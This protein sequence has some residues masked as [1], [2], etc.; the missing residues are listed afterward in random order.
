MAE[1]QL[2]LVIISRPDIASLIIGEELL[3]LGDWQRGP[4]VEGCITHGFCDTRI[5]WLDS[6]LLW[7]DDLDERWR[8]A[9]TE[10]VSE[11]IFPSR[12][13]A[14]SGQPSLT[15][16]PIGIPHLSSQDEIP[17]GGK[18]AS[19]P[20]P[21]P[22]LA[23]WF[24]ELKQMGDASDLCDEFSFTLEATHHG[25]WLKT[26]CM[27]IEIGSTESYWG[28]RDAARI[29]A[30]II[31]RGLGLDGGVGIGNWNASAA[32]EKVVVGIGGGHYAPFIGR[33]A[34]HEGV[35][36]GH[37]LANHSL[38]MIRPDEQDDGRAG[39]TAPSGNWS[40]AIDS[41]IESTR[42]AFPG[43]DVW[44]YLDR[45]SFKGWQRQA[46]RVHL[47]AIGVP[48]GRTRDFISH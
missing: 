19:C 29:L 21:N 26:P 15:V 25:P 48:M 31:W 5:W 3:E 1:P 4:D 37:V 28:R 14:T 32:G 12:H 34:L 41:A 46:I 35:W 10:E 33:L 9:T 42:H 44:A 20:P 13:S 2:K 23:A 45:K 30:D 36:L 22:R 11:I 18:A 6:R 8:Q 24:R 39:A 7:E 38:P 16:H 40:Q 47:E 43:A 17:F 27:F